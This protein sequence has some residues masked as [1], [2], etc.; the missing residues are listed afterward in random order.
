MRYNGGMPSV[1][2]ESWF[3]AIADAALDIVFVIGTDGSVQYV[4]GLGAKWIGVPADQIIGKQMETL[5][6]PATAA[7]Q[8]REIREV[9]E[10]GRPFATE[11]ISEVNGLR[12][13]LDTRLIPLRDEAGAVTGVMGISR[14]T[15]SSRA[16]ADALRA[17]EERFRALVEFS[18]EVI[19]INDL[20]G[21]RLFVSGSVQRVLGYT[22]QEYLGITIYDMAH[23]D[24]VPALRKLFAD[25]AATSHTPMQITL[26]VRHKD[27]SERWI[28]AVMTNLSDVPAISGL[29]INLH[30]ITELRRAQEAQARAS[31]LERITKIMTGRELKMTELKDELEKLRKECEPYLTKKDA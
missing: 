19:V 10:S 12:R 2:S 13:Y 14:D 27:G 29:V 11:D 7:R 18:D 24:D 21:K 3:R 23:P 30:D 26:R 28:H 1:P 4:N 8:S 17:S 5:F 9:I 31:E 22:P 6:A 20:N 16:A 15:T 25:A